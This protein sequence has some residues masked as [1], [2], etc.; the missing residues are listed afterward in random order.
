M[1]VGEALLYMYAVIL[2][3]VVL[4]ALVWAAHDTDGTD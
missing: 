4:G 1:T 2:V 3:A